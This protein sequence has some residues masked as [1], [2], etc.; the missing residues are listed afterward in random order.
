MKYHTVLTCPETIR[1]HQCCLISCIGLSSLCNSITGD[2][3][4]KCVYTLDMVIAQSDTVYYLITKLK[5]NACITCIVT[6]N[7]V[8]YTGFS[9]SLKIFSSLIKKNFDVNTLRTCTY[10]MVIEILFLF[11]FLLGKLSRV[12]VSR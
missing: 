2:S 12:N 10:V 1:I 5:S 11:F 3:L 9:L 4:A 7:Y 8:N 6:F